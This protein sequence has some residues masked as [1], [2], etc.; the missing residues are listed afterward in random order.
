M[1]D[2]PYCKVYIFTMETKEAIDK[3]KKDLA[4][5]KAEG[6]DIV[7]IEAL[8]NYLAELE[9]GATESAEH[10][11]LEYQRDLAFYEAQN[12]ANLE[13][14]RSVISSAKE[15]LNAVVL[16]NGGAVVVFLGFLGAMLSRGGSEQ[17][18]LKLTLPLALFGFGVLFGALGFGTRYCSQFSYSKKWTKAGHIFS[19]LSTFLAFLAYLVFGFGVYTAYVAFTGHFSKPSSL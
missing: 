12:K 5:I 14:F 4:A 2:S 11:R 7:R 3:F 19:G 6:H 8:E 9:K 10:R 15:A 13:M 18:G 1:F 17:L 16:I